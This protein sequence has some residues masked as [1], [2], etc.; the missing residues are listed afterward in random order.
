MAKRKPEQLKILPDE[1]I[2]NAL[3][4]AAD[5]HV[6]ALDEMKESKEKKKKTEEKLI[7][8]MNHAMKYKIRHHGRVFELSNEVPAQKIKVKD[9][10]KN[11]G[12]KNL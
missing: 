10:E 9:A 3:A 8:E 4:V 2:S 12:K 1:N 11:K 7:K 6:A 5:E